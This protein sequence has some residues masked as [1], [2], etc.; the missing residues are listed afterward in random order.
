MM[1]NKGFCDSQTWSV[2]SKELDCVKSQ[3]EARFKGNSSNICA[4]VMKGGERLL[5]S[6]MSPV[7][8]RAVGQTDGLVWSQMELAWERGCQNIPGSACYFQGFTRIITFS[9]CAS[10]NTDKCTCWL[11][12]EELQTTKRSPIL[13]DITQKGFLKILIYNYL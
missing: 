8:R 9:F 2:S 13:G 10:I 11:P 6:G 1:I 12:I 5:I 7:G 3:R 4:L